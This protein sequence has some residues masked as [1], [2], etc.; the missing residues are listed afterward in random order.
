M[1]K[2]EK[3]QL[4]HESFENAVRL[5]RPTFSR[6]IHL[7]RGRW[8]SIKETQ[9]EKKTTTIFSVRLVVSTLNKRPWMQDVP[10]G[11]QKEQ[12]LD[13]NEMTNGMTKTEVR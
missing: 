4:G 2:A 11:L 6:T 5:F 7:A 1:E 3:L 13:Q 8:L 10:T 9:L 12:D